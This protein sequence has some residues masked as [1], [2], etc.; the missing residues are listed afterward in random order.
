[1]SQDPAISP[2]ARIVEAA[3]LLLVTQ[4]RE[5]VT[6]RAVSA[7]AQVQAPTIYRQFGD[8]R[9]LLDA[10]ASHGFVAYLGTKRSRP[11][12]ADPV[13]DLRRG[14]DLH[15]DFGLT[16]PAVYALLYGE[17]SPNGE[18]AAVQEGH[19]IL[20][21]L[22]ERIAEAGR[23]RCE[24]E[25]A[26]RMVH[27]ACKGVTL[28]LLAMPPEHRDAGLSEAMR[29]TLL[30]AVTIDATHTRAAPAAESA[31]SRLARHAVALKASLA[32]NT[33]LTPSEAALMSDWLARL[34]R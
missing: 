4:G 24:V 6:T 22:V 15:V 32:D 2:R 28:T 10:A 33:A 27:S 19:A 25:R 14:W 34:A 26:M 8:M 18:P 29:E 23:L 1:M 11:R 5:A 17:P 30:A 31:Q 16:Q 21:G 9:G 7:A 13:E 20:R 3:Y 12:E